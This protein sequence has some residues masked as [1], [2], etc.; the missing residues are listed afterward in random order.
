MSCI[1][2]G[3]QSLIN[4]RDSN[5]D[6]VHCAV[7]AYN[8]ILSDAA[9]RV[10]QVSVF[11]RKF[12]KNIYVFSNT[13]N[14]WSILSYRLSDINSLSVVGGRSHLTIFLMTVECSRAVM[15]LSYS[16][17]FPIPILTTFPLIFLMTDKKLMRRQ[18]CS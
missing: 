18:F 6:Y 3:L 11:F 7:H 5:A 14:H 17:C 2:E 15:V 13:I 12:G 10:T 16:V 4:E 9:K 8:L 1:Y